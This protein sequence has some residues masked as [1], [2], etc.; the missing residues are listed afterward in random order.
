M[1]LKIS[2]VLGLLHVKSYVGGQSHPAGVLLKFGEV[3]LAPSHLMPGQNYEF[4]PKIAL[5]LLQNGTN[6]TK[7]KLKSKET[8]ENQK[9]TLADLI[10]E[11]L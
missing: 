10:S 6:I 8:I 2:R 4:H 3:V 9:A 7:A 5:V 1:P 11:D